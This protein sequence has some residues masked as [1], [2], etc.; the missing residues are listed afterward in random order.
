M[1]SAT[2]YLGSSTMNQRGN[3]VQSMENSSL[4]NELNLFQ[5]HVTDR[6]NELSSS[7]SNDDLLSLSWVRNLLDTF[8]C[9]QEEFRMILH[10]RRSKVCKPPLDRLVNEFYERS[11]KALD[12]CNAVRD[13]V[14]MVRQWEKLLEIVL[15]ALDHKRIIS[16]GQFRRAKKALV[17]LA[18]GML[19]DSSKDSNNGFSFA[20][21]NRSFGRNNVHH[22]RRD[23]SA[24]G[25]F[26]SLSWSVSRNWS[27]ARQLQAIGSNLCFPKNNDLVATN[28][29]AL[30]IYTMSSILLFTMWALVAAIPCQDRGLHLNF[31]IPRQLSWAAPMTL[32]HE[33]ILEESKKRERKNSCGLL[34]EIQKIEKCARVMNDMADSLEFPLSEEKEEEVRVKVD[35]VVN[36]CESLKD[37]LD[38]LERQVREVFHRIVLGRMEGIDFLS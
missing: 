28:G 37:G 31:S 20:S 33:R 35:D 24:L 30:T 36:V 25:H 27:A 15:C 23:S 2:E 1:R 38:P 5:K 11:V 21:R 6:F 10:N 19:D 34:K 13:G 14:E 29:L 16:E 22:L 12:V 9:C 26:R 8:L 7:V 17:D 32:L 18:I 3:Q 4:E